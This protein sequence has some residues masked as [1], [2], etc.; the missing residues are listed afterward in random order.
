MTRRRNRAAPCRR[1]GVGGLPEGPVPISTGF[2]ELR[3]DPHAPSQVTV[4][5]NG[6]PS[7]FNDIDDPRWLE[8]EYMQY[9]AAVVD[10]LTDGP[11]TVVHLGAGACTFA[12]WVDAVRP[13]SAQLAVDVDAELVRL[14]RE[15]FDL[16]RSPALRLRVGEAREA[17]V[18]MAAQSVDVVIRDAFATDS[19]PAHLCTVEF[20]EEVA[21][22]LRPDG[23]YLAN[24]ADRP[25][26][27]LARAEA[28]T[29]RKV[30]NDV[31][32]V[33][34][35][36][37]VKGRR[38]GNVV[39]AAAHRTTLDDP[40]LARELRSLAVPARLL[41]GDDLEALVSGARPL[42]D[43]TGPDSEEATPDGAASASSYG[44]AGRTFSAWGPLGP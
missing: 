42:Y 37:Q 2:A 14:A 17:V 32:V 26:L 25:P 29:L 12:R 39:L 27:R 1:R 43:A 21:R 22:V 40:A 19:T 13:G 24:C 4:L 23:L 28:A 6:V 3:R 33:A 36:A 41:H 7:S 16:P 10:R 5:V 31:A 44:Q 20:A 30:F 18:A 15:W 9:M 8:F 34:E 35:P 11:L 38:H